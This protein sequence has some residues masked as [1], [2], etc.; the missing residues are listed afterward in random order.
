MENNLKK[1]KYTY[2][3]TYIYLHI[4]LYI[5]ETL[6]YTPETNK[7]SHSYTSIQ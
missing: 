2:I 3:Y 7:A 5:T 6:C 4:Y 1:N